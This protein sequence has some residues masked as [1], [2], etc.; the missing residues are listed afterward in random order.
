MASKRKET[1]LFKYSFKKEVEHKG[2]LAVIKGKDFLDN[3]S[4][5][6]KCRNCKDR[7]LSKQS[8]FFF[9]T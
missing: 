6:F 2:T 3:Q 4:G 1:T 8:N 9:F 7:L 5:I